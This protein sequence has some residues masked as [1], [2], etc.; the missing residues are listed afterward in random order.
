[1]R[2]HGD[3]TLQ[4]QHIKKRYRVIHEVDN[5]FSQIEAND[6]LESDLRI[7]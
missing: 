6:R 7:D 5:H 3:I 4:E 1:M 2:S